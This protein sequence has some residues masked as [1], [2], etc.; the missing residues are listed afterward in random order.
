MAG[1][2]DTVAARGAAADG[3]DGTPLSAHPIIVI[4]VIPITAIIRILPLDLIL[5]Y[6]FLFDY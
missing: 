3:M 6:S 5:P 2:T 1:V 4:T